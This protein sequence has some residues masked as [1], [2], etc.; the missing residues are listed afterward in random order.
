MY[1]DWWWVFLSAVLPIINLGMMG[2]VLGLKPLDSV[3]LA[4][5]AGVS[6]GAESSVDSFGGGGSAVGP[7]FTDDDVTGVVLVGDTEPWP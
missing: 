4:D 6:R 3:D 2:V 5:K 1:G 7:N